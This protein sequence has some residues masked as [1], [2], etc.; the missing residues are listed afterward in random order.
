MISNSQP[1][2]TVVEMLIQQ[3]SAGVWSPEVGGLGAG[4]F[5]LPF[6]GT[7][8]LFT[9]WKFTNFENSVHGI[10]DTAEFTSSRKKVQNMGKD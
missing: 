8:C 1:Q 4:L 7:E 10:Q 3:C 9:V 2:G 5:C 6:L